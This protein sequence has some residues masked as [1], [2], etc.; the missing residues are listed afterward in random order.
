MF[1]F[2]KRIWYVL[3]AIIAIKALV[4]YLTNTNVLLSLLLSLP[5][6]LVAISFHEYAHAYAADKL[7]DETPRQQGRLNLN[8]LSH[9]DPIGFIM[10]VFAGFGWGKP[11]Q[12]NP[13]NFNRDISMSKAEAIVAAAGPIMNFMLAIA[14]TIISCIIPKF[15]M[16][17]YYSQIGIITSRIIDYSIIINLGLGIFN[18]I[19]LPPL[20]GSKILNNF[21]PYNARIWFESHEQIFYIIFVVLWVT[22]LAGEIISPL[23]GVT[24]KGLV[25]LGMKLFGLLRG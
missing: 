22:G 5:G 21:L 3:I 9:I 25:Q 6:V 17:F 23:I 20:D 24:Y 10:L 13:R 14:F 16:D 19:P 11:V 8:P 18:L 12:I 1:N 7:G 2:D 15:F 4:P